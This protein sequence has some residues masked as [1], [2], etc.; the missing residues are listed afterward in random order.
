[1]KKFSYNIVTKSIAVILICICAVLVVQGGVA[2]M[3][4]PYESDY[5]NTWEF[6][7]AFIQKAGY[8]RDWIVRY[9]DESIFDPDKITGKEINAYL[10]GS[11][12]DEIREYNKVPEEQ[13]G[14]IGEQSIQ[15]AK[16]G[17]IKDRKEYFE[18]LKRELLKNNVNI[19]FYAINNKTGEVVT[20]I[21]GTL[22]PDE[23]IELLTSR[24]AYII[25]NGAYIQEFVTTSDRGERAYHVRDSKDF[26]YYDGEDFNGQNDYEIY[27]AMA[28]ELVPGDHFYEESR[29]FYRSKGNAEVFIYQF[30]TP[31]LIVGVLLSIYGLIVVGR[32]AKDKEVHLVAIDK[33]PFEIQVVGYWIGLF[34]CFVGFVN[35]L[36]Y[37]DFYEMIREGSIYLGLMYLSVGVGCAWT[38]LFLSSW[39]RHLKNHSFTQH[40]GIVKGARW[41][42]NKGIKEGNLPVWAVVG[43]LGYSVINLGL[44]VMIGFG[45]FWVLGVMGWIAFNGLALVGIIK[46]VIDYRE[47]SKGLKKIASGELE[48]KVKL[49]YSLPVME[50]MAGTINHVGEGLESAVAQKLK[51]EK[52]KTELIT[53]VSHDLKTPLTSI[54]SYIDLLKQEKIENATA[55]EYIEVLSERSARLKQLVEDLVE[56]SKVATGNVKTTM[57]ILELS[58]LV[59]QSIGEYNDRLEANGLEVII[60]RLDEIS[61][62]ADG[63]HMWRVIENL[64]SNVSKYA[65][66]NTRVYVEVRKEMAYGKLIIKNISKDPL[67][68]MDPSE[69]TE[70]F[71]RG[72]ESRTTEG[73]GLGL[74]IAQSLVQVQGGQFKIELDGD[75]FKV[76]V[77]MPL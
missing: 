38:L 6:K 28:K 23:M 55:N 25:G 13:I 67:N 41:I 22:A 40:I 5:Y 69:L 10:V 18:K 31:G 29:A 59:V 15:F 48:T 66:P 43:I 42:L 14:L 32:R 64:L 27:V 45:G 4:A 47:L 2:F 58:Q 51:S 63:R 44:A 20:S 72:D 50:E 56:A 77:V 7:D 19:D 62:M 26:E 65:L 71:I 46:I 76:E 21:E 57:E 16:D 37:R 30:A 70:R 54:I 60:S 61:V 75:L 74:A 12:T 9:A 11:S 33:I 36:D 3:D 35:S 73:S 52:L 34:I 24:E 68:M 53:N 49:S 17:I 8:V 1:M 39:I